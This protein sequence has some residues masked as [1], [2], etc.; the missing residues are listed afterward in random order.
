MKTNRRK[1]QIGRRKIKQ[2]QKNDEKLSSARATDL[3]YARF[4]TTLHQKLG[5]N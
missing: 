1:F 2:S 3:D 4:L 5:I